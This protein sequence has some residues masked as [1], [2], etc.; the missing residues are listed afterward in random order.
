MTDIRRSLPT[1]RQMVPELL[2]ALKK[3]GGSGSVKEIE[4]LV[5]DQLG[6]SPEQLEVRHDKS[7]SEFQYRFAW[8]RTYAKR[9]GLVK[10]ER[11]NQWA[12]SENRPVN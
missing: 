6:L 2:T 9:D 11:R 7:R 1:A 8:S 5:A 4:S 10:S 3:I 12:L